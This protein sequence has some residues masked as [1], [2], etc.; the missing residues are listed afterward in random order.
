MARQIIGIIWR[1]TTFISHFSGEEVIAP[2]CF[3]VNDGHKSL[4][5]TVFILQMLSICILLLGSIRCSSLRI[6]SQSF[7]SHQTLS[8]HLEMIVTMCCNGMHTRQRSKVGVTIGHI[9]SCKVLSEV[10][11]FLPLSLLNSDRLHHPIQIIKYA[12]VDCRNRMYG[13]CMPFRHP[14][15]PVSEWPYNVHDLVENVLNILY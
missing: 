10:S 7:V 8:H 1:L 14:H 6:S 4:F 12:T 3:G 15:G 13:N 11:I 5:G 9:L 2:H